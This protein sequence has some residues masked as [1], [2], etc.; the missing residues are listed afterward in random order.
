MN[1]KKLKLNKSKS[2]LKV[3]KERFNSLK[4]TIN[5]NDVSSKLHAYYE[6]KERNLS[7]NKK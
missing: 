4:K 2:D 3:N 5:V 1:S 7:E 6:L